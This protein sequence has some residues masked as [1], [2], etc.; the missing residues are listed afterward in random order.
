MSRIAV[1]I[2]VFNQSAAVIRTLN[3]VDSQQADMEFFVVDD[4]SVPALEITTAD[5]QHPIHVIRLDQNQG[6]TVARNRALAEIGKAKFDYVAL[7][8]AGDT[9]IGERMRR[10]AEFLDENPDVAV[11]GAWAQYVNLEGQPLYVHKAPV[12]HA[13]ILQRM[14]FVSAF[15][16]PASMI[17][18]ESLM[19]VGGYDEAYPIASDYE[20][21]FRLTKNYS[22]ANLPEVMIKKEDNPE[23]ISLGKRR[24]SLLYRLKA[25][26]QHF[27]VTSLRAYLG[28]FWTFGLL[29]LPYSAVVAAKRRRGY[30]R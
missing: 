30:A 22:A 11:V 20:L 6:C 9:D 12:S 18:L 16:H 23:S 13:E 4:G 5:F 25:Q 3:S 15:A 19:A 1:L 8:D 28:L 21:F 2:P 24:A 29:L 7:Q 17:R 26:R 10:Q 14:P 27:R